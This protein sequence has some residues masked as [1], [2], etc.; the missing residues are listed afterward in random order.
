MA[1]DN[2]SANDTPTAEKAGCHPSQTVVS[3]PQIRI[4][5]NADYAEVFVKPRI[6][7]DGLHWWGVLVDFSA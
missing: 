5:L 2:S 7:A 1:P 6:C 4:R 3:R